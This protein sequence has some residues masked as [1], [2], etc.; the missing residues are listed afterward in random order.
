MKKHN[1]KDLW[2]KHKNKILIGIGFVTVGGTI[3]YAIK[4]KQK[5][6]YVLDDFKIDFGN[7]IEGVCAKR[8]HISIP[9]MDGMRCLDIAKD[10]DGKVVWL[11]DCVLA[12][13]GQLGENLVKIE[14]V[15]SDMVAT[16][17]IL[18]KNN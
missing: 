16:M 7:F 1:V 8:E 4:A 6:D 5:S 10:G 17:V 14:G 15:D 11:E 13:A 12:K 9:E 3:I 18:A 2:R